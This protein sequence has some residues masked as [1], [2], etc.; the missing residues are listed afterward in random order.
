MKMLALA[1]T[2]AAVTGQA[3][4]AD[5][6][7][8]ALK[9]PPLMPVA[10]WTG[11]YVGINGGIAGMKG[12]Q[13]TYDD[14]IT[15]NTYVFPV[16]VDPGTTTSGLFGFHL[17]YNNQFTNNWLLGIEGDWDWTNLKNSG[18]QGLLCSSNPVP[19]GQCGGVIALS[20]SAAFETDVKW[21]AS[22]R[23]RLGFV[24]TPQWLLY[25][26]GGVAF[27]HADDTAAVT[28][29]GTPPTICPGRAQS[30]LSKFGDTRVGAVVGGGVEFKPARNWIFGAE[31][32]FYHFAGDKTAG[33]SWFH[34]DDGSP[35]PFYECTVAG[36]NCATFTFRSFDVQTGRVR[37]SYQLA[38]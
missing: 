4:A 24:W 14:T 38:P 17:G 32:L 9:A 10:T 13:A 8:K 1:L 36:Q 30:I 2:F 18:S 22:V 27:E 21:L 33:G 20:D 12:P 28:C 15:V 11:F 6:N 26:T 34:P 5:M 31:Y 35:A 23:G 7:V 16:T 19:R 29:T 25:A 3:L 37:L